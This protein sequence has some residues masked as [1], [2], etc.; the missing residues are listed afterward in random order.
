[1]IK[2]YSYSSSP[3]YWIFFN[4]KRLRVT[5]DLYLFF[6]ETIKVYDG[7]SSLRKRLFRTVTVSKMCSK[8]ELLMTAMRAFVVTQD[9]RNF[10]LLD[11]YANCDGDGDRDEEIQ[12]PYPIQKLKRKEGRR[13]AILLGLRDGDN[14]SGVIKVYARKLNVSPN[15]LTIP[16]ST[17][18]T[19]EQVIQEAVAR[20][21]LGTDRIDTYQ[22]VKVTLEAGRGTFKGWPSFFCSKLSFFLSVTETVLAL[23]DIPWEVLK[24]RGHESVRLMELTRF[25]LELRK[26]PHGPDV[27]LFIGNLPANL[28]QKNYETIILDYLDEGRPTFNKK[29]CH[30]HGFFSPQGASLRASAL[31][32]TN[33]VPCLLHSTILTAQFRHT[34]Y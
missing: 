28:S 2:V 14:D 23:D 12:D 27:A 31:S 32:I 10:Y 30:I 16:V 4:F 18:I 1:M 13:P 11:V 19:T 34:S 9:S 20:F 15:S 29:L 25:Y 3:V 6:S 24:R 33:T 7:Y 22:L 21:R 5:V 8:E 26:D 17:T